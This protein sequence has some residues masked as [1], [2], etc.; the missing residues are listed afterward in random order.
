MQ[1]QKLNIND[2]CNLLEIPV[3][4]YGLNER[5]SKEVGRIQRLRK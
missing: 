3:S 5:M 1:E 4:S 2:V